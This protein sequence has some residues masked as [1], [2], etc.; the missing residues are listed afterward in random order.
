MTSMTSMTSMTW[1]IH[2]KSRLNDQTPQI[3]DW[4]TFHLLRR[5]IQ[6]FHSRS[7]MN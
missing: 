2:S 3:L 7:G 6:F 5:E 4:H 1:N